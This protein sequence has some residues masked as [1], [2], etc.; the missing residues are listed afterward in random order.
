MENWNVHQ[1]LQF[2]LD[3]ETVWTPDVLEVYPTERRCKIFNGIDKLIWVLGID[4]NI[5]GLHAGKLV[6][7][8]RLPLHD[9]LGSQSSNIAE[10][11]H[12]RSICDD[13]DHISFIGIAEC[14]CGVICDLLTWNGDTRRVSQTQVVL[15]LHFLGW[16]DLI[17][18]WLT[19][20]VV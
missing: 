14:I 20:F 5:D 16:H 3:V 10:A 12:R 7:K 8:H 6:E 2:F 13:R 17:L 4:A 11:E 1:L 19:L 9:R 15:R 18:T